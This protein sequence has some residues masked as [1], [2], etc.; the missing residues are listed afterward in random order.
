M[1]R[2]GLALFDP[3]AASA[4]MSGPLQVHV[5]P[6]R[7]AGCQECVVRC[8]SGALSIDPCS[9]TA[10]SDDHLCVGCRQCERT[11]PFG[12]IQVTGKPS[13]AP[14]RQPSR[15]RP[16]TLIFN[17]TETRL[18]FSSWD[19]AEREAARCLNCPD[20]TCVQ[21]CPAHN[22]IPGFIA[23]I[24]DRD[25]GA[26]QKILRE[27]SLLPDI[28]SR[29]CDQSTQCEGA[30][31]W[32]LAGAEPVSI[33]LLE[34]F[35]TDRSQ[36]PP[37]TI[38]G[39]TYPEVSAAVVGSGPAG[40]AAA[41]DLTEAGVQVHLYERLHEPLGVLGWGIPAFTLPDAVAWRP[42][43]ALLSAGVV[44]HTGADLGKNLS[45]ADLRAK[46]GAVL[47]AF[48][49]SE[50]L[51]LRVPGADLPWVEDAT[52]FLWRTRRALAQTERLP[53]LHPGVRVLVIGAGNTA[54]DVARSARRLGATV[55]AV[56]WMDRRFARVRP[57]ELTE[58]E[59]EGVDVQFETSVTRFETSASGSRL[60]YLAPTR[61]TRAT[62]LPRVVGSGKPFAVDRA[63]MAMGYRLNAAVSRELGTKL[64]LAA[65]DML[66]VVSD[67]AFLATGLPAGDPVLARMIEERQAFLKRAP[68]P[69][70]DGVWVVGDALSGPATVVAAMAQ[71][72]TAARKMAL[73]LTGQGEMEIEVGAEIRAVPEEV[74]Q[75]AVGELPFL[76][77]WVNRIVAGAAP[78]DARPTGESEP[79]S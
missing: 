30:C 79:R 29:V 1:A 4:C 46:H 56:D 14:R 36:I 68:E 49:A 63:V 10:I 31:S 39:R 64:P 55:T 3:K 61:Q 17:T 62:V 54:M 16:E 53:D 33:G 7:C 75:H 38:P 24:R 69:I 72:R 59:D 50:P 65:R 27:T 73:W 77:R 32:S 12:A 19:E 52:S 48:G 23:A 2:Q 74:H 42:L 51:A 15:H 71:G 45:L 22:D 66:P 28:C 60:A 76:A 34:R 58:A 43:E 20:P 67:R 26:A 35:V 25:L 40:L 18:G 6:G 11:C 21:G 44:L 8:P 78:Y 70:A 47:L 37:V 13:V 5:D 57:D 41:W 9:W